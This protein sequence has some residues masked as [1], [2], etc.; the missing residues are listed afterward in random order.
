MVVPFMIEGFFNVIVFVIAVVN[1][2]GTVFQSIYC[3]I[4]TDYKNL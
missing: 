4:L 3:F 1:L 2:I